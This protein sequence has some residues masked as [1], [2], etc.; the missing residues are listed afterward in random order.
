MF[1]WFSQD[2]IHPIPITWDKEKNRHLKSERNISFEEVVFYLEKGQ[3]GRRPPKTPN[4]NH[5][6]GQMA[7]N[8][9]R[10]PLKNMLKRLLK[11]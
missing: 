1:P 4:I 8:Q 3:V 6:V 7:D 11:K 10:Q 2:G 5:W 9:Q